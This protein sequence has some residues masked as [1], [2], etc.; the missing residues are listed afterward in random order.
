MIKAALGLESDAN[1]QVASIFK[2][3]FRNKIK[4]Q[5]IKGINPTEV[6]Q[7]VQPTIAQGLQDQM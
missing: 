3:L 4:R 7:N 5:M 1:T 6:G 2:N